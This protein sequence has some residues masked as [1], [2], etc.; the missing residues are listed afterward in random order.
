MDFNPNRTWQLGDK[1]KA[2]LWYNREGKGNK[3]TRCGRYPGPKPWYLWTLLYEAKRT[4]EM[5]LN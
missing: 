3:L 1:T 2:W 4:L 5:L